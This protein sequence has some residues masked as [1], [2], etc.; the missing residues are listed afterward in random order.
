MQIKIFQINPER[1]RNK[2]MFQPLSSLEGAD[3]DPY[4]Y[5]L[6][7]EGDVN[8]KNLEEVYEYFNYYTHPLMYGHSLSMSDIVYV[9]GQPDIDDNGSFYCD[10]LRWEKVLFNPNAPRKTVPTIKVVVV[11]PGKEPKIGQMR[12]TLEAM[13]Q[14]VGGYIE[15]IALNNR[16]HIIC[17]EEGYLHNLPKN[18]MLSDGTCVQGTFIVCGASGEEFCSLSDELAKNAV[19][20]FE[21]EQHIEL[22]YSQLKEMF[23]TYNQLHNEGEYMKGYIVISEDSFP[24]KYSLKSRTYEVFSSNKAFKSDSGVSIFGS[25][26][27][28]SD[29]GV[30]LDQYLADE[31]GGK[32]GWKIEKCYIIA[33][34]PLQLFEEQSDAISQNELDGEEELC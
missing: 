5:E 15:H 4:I 30:R 6:V 19:Q 11:E 9:S 14:A 34:D 1:D 21:E 2:V 17:N 8:C 12:N 10:T 26:L 25:S 33:A 31:K 20:M 13:Q 24:L 27:D 22:T 3:P 28:R 32:Y 29:I 23:Q 16:L 7:F 18:R